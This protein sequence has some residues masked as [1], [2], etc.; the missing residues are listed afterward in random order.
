MFKK[1]VEN[2]FDLT[3]GSRFLNNSDYKPNF[4]RKSGISLLRKLIYFFYNVRVLDC[5]SG[6]Q[7]LS[8][9]LIGEIVKD[10]NFEYS[11]VGIICKTSKAHLSIAEE[12]VNMKPRMSGESSFNFTNSFSYMF[13]NLLAIITS[14]SFNLKKKINLCLCTQE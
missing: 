5:T 10:E 6:C 13:K 3:V 14:F 11:E 2:K 1:T 7:I 9:K 12:F 8:K 4:L